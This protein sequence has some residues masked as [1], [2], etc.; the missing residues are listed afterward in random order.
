MAH[1]NYV[2]RSKYFDDCRTYIYIYISRKK[3]INV[4]NA[5][6]P[7]NISDRACAITKCS[8]NIGK[9]QGQDSRSRYYQNFVDVEKTNVMIKLP[10]IARQVQ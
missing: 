5:R 2:N 4:E 3:S 1:F 8:R 7:E 9:Y 6:F 10:I